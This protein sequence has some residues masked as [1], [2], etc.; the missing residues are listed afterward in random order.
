MTEL[1]Y[2]LTK[3]AMRG[4][5]LDLIEIKRITSPKSFEERFA[6]TFGVNPL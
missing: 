5:D 2:I 3:R 1:I 4:M 6:F